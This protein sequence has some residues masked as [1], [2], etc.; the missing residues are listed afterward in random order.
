MS[1]N[2]LDIPGKKRTEATASASFDD[3]DHSFIILGS[4]GSHSFESLPVPSSP[5]MEANSDSDLETLI[6]SELDDS[7]YSTIPEI[8]ESLIATIQPGMVITTEDSR[9][10][11]KESLEEIIARSEQWKG[12]KGQK[13]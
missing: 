7:D 6:N 9:S 2:F 12:K 10:L 1:S 4:S 11:L 8:C 13:K 5:I 3:D